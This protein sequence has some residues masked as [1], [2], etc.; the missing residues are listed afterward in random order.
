MRNRF[1]IGSSLTFNFYGNLIQSHFVGLVGCDVTG[2]KWKIL[3]TVQVV[4]N[5]VF[6]SYF[7]PKVRQIFMSG[8]HRGQPLTSRQGSKSQTL[9]PKMEKFDEANVRNLCFW[10]VVK[11]Y[12]RKVWKVTSLV[13][14]KLKN[15]FY[16]RLNI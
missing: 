2:T 6:D 8:C 15:L 14:V 1:Q 12:P 3:C 11:K 4:T 9:F 13:L 7:K 10:W 5:S 16:L